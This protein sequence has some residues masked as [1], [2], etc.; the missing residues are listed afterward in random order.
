VYNI[1]TMNKSNIF[2]IS[3]PTGTGESTI[4]NEIIKRFPN[5]TRLVTATSRSPRLNE[6]NGVDYYF[7]SKQD[8][9][10]EIHQGNILE[11]TYV[12]NR[13]TYYG[14]YKLDLED[15]LAKGFNLIINPD[16]VGTKFYK[17]NYNAVTIF[18]KPNS[19]EDLKM[20]L[21]KRDPNITDDELQKRLGNAE[22]EIKNDEK[23]YDYSVINEEG[24]LE[25]AIEKVTEIIKNHLS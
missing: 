4:T 23:F 1:I 5:F 15:K 14:T 11:H 6:K 22:D 19:L 9:E 24:K 20:R 18:I 2:I 17:I 21:L 13:D 16:I 7:F 8:F 10:N 25:E 3:G 12:A